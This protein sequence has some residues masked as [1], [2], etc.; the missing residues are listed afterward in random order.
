[1][2]TTLCLLTINLAQAQPERVEERSAR[3]ASLVIKVQ[4]IDDVADALVDK[5]RDMGGYFSS[6]THNHISFKI[7]TNASEDFLDFSSQHGIVVDRYYS[8]QTLTE[9]IADVQ[10]ELA[11]AKKIE[12]MY[13]DGEGV[14]FF[15]LR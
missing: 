11:E 4:R 13:S 14:W 9:A 1:M 3:Q 8:S 15:S 5:A 7:P 6:R 2:I 10:S 12:E